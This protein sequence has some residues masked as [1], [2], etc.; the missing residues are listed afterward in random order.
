MSQHLKCE[1]TCAAEHFDFWLAW[2]LE[3]HTETIDVTPIKRFGVD[4]TQLTRSEQV[5]GCA[6][7]YRFNLT[8]SASLAKAF[9]A[10]VQQQTHPIELSLFALLDA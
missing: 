4:V 9:K 8:L 5:K 6:D 10:R 3:N 7:Y 2:L 1:L